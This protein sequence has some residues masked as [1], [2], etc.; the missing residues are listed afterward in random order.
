MLTINDLENGIVVSIEGDPF[1]ILEVSHQHIGRGGSNVQT[2]IKNLRT[3]AVLSRN[4]KPADKFEEV[5]VEKKPMKFLYANRGEY[6]FCEE[7]KP[8]NRFSLPEGVM[9]D[10][11]SF[12][13][14]N[15]IVEAILV[16]G[17]VLNVILPIK[18]D[19]KVMEAPPGIK[20]NTA[21]GGTKLVTLETG[22]EVAVPL[23]INE[24][25]IVRVNTLTKSYV[26]R[27]EKTSV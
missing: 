22:A 12:L 21:Q 2:R 25:D 11:A 26:E 27:V 6:W 5:E 9:G 19:L 20:G 4:F 17:S 13:K 15:T 14:A 3:G 1:E 7:G 8:A 23:F 16:R 24:G 10:G 18:V